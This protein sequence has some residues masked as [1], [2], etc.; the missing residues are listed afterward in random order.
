MAIS[1][2]LSDEEN[3]LIKN[4][5]KLKGVSISELIRETIFSRIEGELDLEAY[6]KAMIE[7]HKNPI[8]YSHEEAKKMLGLG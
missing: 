8:T 7:H 3:L 2:R 4:Y 6:K 1:L 5:A